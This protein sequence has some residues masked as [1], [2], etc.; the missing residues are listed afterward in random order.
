MP[1]EVGTADAWVQGCGCDGQPSLDG[2][3]T[4]GLLGDVGVGLDLDMPGGV[5][6]SC[7][8]HHGGGGAGDGEE[9]AVDAGDLFPVPRVREVDAGADDVLDGGAGL[10]EGCGDDGETLLG[11]GCGVGVVRADGPG[12]G[13]VDVRADA[14]GAGK[15]RSRAR[16]GC[17]QGCFCGSCLF[18]MSP[19]CEICRDCWK[20]RCSPSRLKKQDVCLGSGSR[21]RPGV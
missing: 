1:A 5:E 18:W 21:V 2:G 19:G 16:R 11:L 8:D 14:N 4:P 6:E 7:D 15:S 13:D 3:L 12:S 20:R 17:C 10:F 9:L